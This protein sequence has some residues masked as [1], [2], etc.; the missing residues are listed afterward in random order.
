MKEAWLG[1]FNVLF[2]LQFEGRTISSS[3]L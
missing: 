1:L 3:Q 2:K